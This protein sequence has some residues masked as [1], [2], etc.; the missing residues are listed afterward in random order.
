MPFFYL[1]KKKERVSLSHRHSILPRKATLLVWICFLGLQLPL[2]NS[3]IDPNSTEMEENIQY[4]KILET[5]SW[6]QESKQTICL[7]INVTNMF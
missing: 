1:K 4:E 6:I 3:F 5:S 2:Q 7:D